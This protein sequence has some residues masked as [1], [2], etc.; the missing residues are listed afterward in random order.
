M[1]GQLLRTQ[2]RSLNKIRILLAA[3][4]LGITAGYA[5]SLITPIIRRISTSSFVIITGGFCLLALALS[6]WLIDV[7]KIRAGAKFFAV[8]GMNPLFIYLFT[9]TGGDEWVRNIGQPFCLGF[10]GWA[11]ERPA[12]LA[13]SLTVL[14]L[15]WSLCYWLYR[16]KIFIRV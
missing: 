15:L 6:F 7:L 9:Q 16:R 1:A 14:A 12:Q 10:F 4:L 2:R 5:L 13:V 11:G 8:V 3:G